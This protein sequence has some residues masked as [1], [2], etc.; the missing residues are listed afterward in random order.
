[1]VASLLF[2]WVGFHTGSQTE[3]RKQQAA[4]LAAEDIRKNG[5]R[6]AEAYKKEQILEARDEIQKLKA[7]AERDCEE[8]RAE[9]EATERRLLQQQGSLV[10]KEQQLSGR[11]QWLTNQEQRI[12]VQEAR[13][14]K[15]EDELSGRQL[16]MVRSEALL[17]EALEKNAE[18]TS[19]E[20]RKELFA[21]V[22]R[23]NQLLLARRVH[24][25][26]QVAKEEADRKAR[27]IITMAIQKWASEQVAEATVSVVNLPNN[28]MKG[29]IIGR[30][31]R[32]IRVLENLTGVNLIV[33]DTPEAVVLSGFDPVKREIARMAVE[34]LVQ[35][36]RIHPT[37][38]EEMVAASR[39]EMEERIVTEGERVALEAGVTGLHPELIRHLGRL[40]FRTSY[41]QNMLCHSLEV[42]FLSG[43]LAAEVGADAE[44]ASRA[45]LLHDLGKAV[46]MDT[47]GPHAKNGADLCSRF[48][49]S[50]AVVHCVEAHHEDIEQQTL[51]AMLVQA[52]DA[53]SAA[54]P[55]AR[56][57]NVDTYI[58]RLEKL[59]RIARSFEGVDQACAIQA[60]R[61]VR[62][63][64]RPELVDD[65]GAT[66]L[67]SQIASRIEGDM[68]YPGQI[69]VTVVRETRFSEYAH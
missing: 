44:I 14:N 7:E 65:V 39:R 30:E 50:A 69:R 63:F 5:E 12:A 17:R 31:G 1:M 6:V 8:R 68:Q 53:I 11:E 19:E 22:E 18:L 10:S 52:A 28:D 48:G 60:G 46:T 66:R 43:R 34:K 58:K 2:F 38:I 26:E 47:D 24:Q 4:R 36:G 61:E 35:D 20:A 49:E 57:E 32:N 55:G 54:R 16:E 23:D 3:V 41:G 29:R 56:R 64:V 9:V 21:Q 27:R 15:Q 51:E 13:L 45:G 37:K 42:S 33:D 59:E 25:A 62:V 40:R 67:A